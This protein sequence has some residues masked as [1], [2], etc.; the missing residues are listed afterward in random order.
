MHL[1]V[2]DHRTAESGFHKHPGAEGFDFY[3]LGTVEVPVT[4]LDEDVMN[5]WPWTG[6]QVPVDLLKMNTNGD[7]V[8]VFNS[9]SGLLSRGA[10]C[11]VMATV[12]RLTIR[13]VVED[14]SFETDQG[15][16]EKMASLIAALDPKWKFGYYRPTQEEYTHPPGAAPL[17]AAAPRGRWTLLN[18]GTV[19]D[20]RPSD[21]FLGVGHG[22]PG[23]SSRTMMKHL[24]GL[25]SEGRT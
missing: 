8:A 11:A 9:A 23:C 3:S 4:T 1:F 15:K 2:P 12:Y 6:D 25:L 22:V 24:S 18:A 19:K 20:L 5:V 17:D 7:E 21:T 13:K 14:V 10:V 16:V